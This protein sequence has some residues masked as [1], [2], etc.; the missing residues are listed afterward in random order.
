MAFL[1]DGQEAGVDLLHGQQE[2]Q[3]VASVAGVR[4]WW[5][6]EMLGREGGTVSLEHQIAGVRSHHPVRLELQANRRVQP[7]M[8]RR[9]WEH[10]RRARPPQATQQITEESMEGRKKKTTLGC[11]ASMRASLGV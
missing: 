4:L 1:T 8:G 2:Y 9:L 11:Q 6:L 7:G 5:C 10:L 3:S